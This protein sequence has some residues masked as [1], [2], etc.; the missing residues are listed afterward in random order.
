M[1][2]FLCL[3]LSSAILSGPV[4]QA[5]AHPQQAHPV[6]GPV[7]LAPQPDIFKKHVA[8]FPR[9]AASPAVSP[10][11]MARINGSLQRL[12]ATVREAAKD[13][14]T[15]AKEDEGKVDPDAW[16]RT[17]TVTMK[18]PR[19]L[20]FLASDDI[21]CGGAYPDA[22]PL[23]MVYD[24]TTGRPLNWLKVLPPN[25]KASLDAAGDGTTIGVVAW[26]ALSAAVMSKADKDCQDAFGDPA[27]PGP[28]LLWL[29]AATGSL[30]A[31]VDGLGHAFA[32]CAGPYTFTVPE[33]RKLGVSS[34][35]LD[36]LDAAHHLQQH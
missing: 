14:Q 12:D 13:C 34:E 15:S 25:A 11:A 23:P 27:G 24:L 8:A 31:D 3:L 18:G 36:S 6:A 5:Q 17:I 9:V 35:L 2:P 28:F 22:S 26:P 30:V 1:R 33:A 19:F 20:S 16:G 29:D 32:D 7:V 10:E 4:L 21:Y